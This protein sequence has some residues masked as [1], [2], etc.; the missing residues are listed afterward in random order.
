MTSEDKIPKSITDQIVEDML[1][2]LKSRDEYTDSVI[3]KLNDVASSGYLTSN[4]KV[5][6][7]IKTFD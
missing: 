6:D 2:K 3:N 7:A 5:T 1:L 4:K